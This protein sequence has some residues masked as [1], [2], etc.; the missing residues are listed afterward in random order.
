MQNVYKNRWMEIYP[1]PHPPS[2]LVS[3]LLL[4]HVTSSVVQDKGHT[5][6]SPQKLS[7]GD[8][9]GGGRKIVD[10]SSSGFQ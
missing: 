7:N 10:M 9:S 5:A 6:H 8:K 1:T 4:F 2:P 3:V